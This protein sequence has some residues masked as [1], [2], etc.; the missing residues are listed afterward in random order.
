V[1]RRVAVDGKMEE[2]AW[3]PAHLECLPPAV[4][5]SS[6]LPPDKCADDGMSNVVLS[7][8]SVKDYAMAMSRWLKRERKGYL[9][10][11]ARV[12]ASVVPT[13]FLCD[14]HG[15]HKGTG[16]C[17]YCLGFEARP[18][19]PPDTVPMVCRRDNCRERFRNIDDMLI[20]GGCRTTIHAKC[21]D[22]PLV[23]LLVTMFPW[24]CPDCKRCSVCGRRQDSASLVRCAVCDRAFHIGCLTPPLDKV[25]DGHQWMCAT[26]GKCSTCAKDLAIEEAKDTSAASLLHRQ[27]TVC[28]EGPKPPPPPQQQ[29]QQGSTAAAAAAAAA[30]SS[31]ETRDLCGVCGKPPP[32]P[33]P[34]AEGKPEEET[35]VPTCTICHK[36][37]HR[38]CSVG[39]AHKRRRV[40][41]PPA[42]AAAE[43]KEDHGAAMDV[44]VC[45]DRQA[46]RPREWVVCIVCHEI[47]EAFL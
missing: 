32:T 47:E 8:R 33:E 1:S 30:A 3:L 45:E 29:Q 28:K 25:P 4:S 39:P 38:E 26:C 10:D 7:A 27:C 23:W 5:V 21:C 19:A 42:P 15:S 24:R 11:R 9:D 36:V 40:E 37:V 43:R 46:K 14:E 22:P 13:C 6:L 2:R 41:A 34:A 20:C 18:D 12:V 35:P 16:F 31:A 44:E 17:K